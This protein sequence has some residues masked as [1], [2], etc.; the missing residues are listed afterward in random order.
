MPTKKKVQSSKSKRELIR[1][2][3][4]MVSGGAYFWSGYFIIVLLTPVI[5]LW[6]ANLIGNGVGI[7]VNF[8]LQHYWVFKTGRG[9]KVTKVSGR[10]VALTAV[11]L[12]LNYYILK[13]LQDD[14][15]IKVAFGQFISAAFFTVW[16]YAWY[17]FWVFKP[18]AK[19]RYAK[20]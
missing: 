13:W 3:E 2:A 15:N 16:N 18:Q 7:T 20:A 8:L 1:F 17:K 19:K 12:V 9:D 10:Y 5:G 14:L 11:N 4:Y 6:W